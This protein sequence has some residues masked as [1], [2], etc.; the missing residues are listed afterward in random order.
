MVEIMTF[1]FQFVDSSFDLFHRHEDS[2]LYRF[3]FD[4]D[5]NLH[6]FFKS[7]FASII[8][9]DTVILGL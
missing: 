7:K 2:Y 9:D 6:S 4:D 8:R 1:L 3:V 5:S